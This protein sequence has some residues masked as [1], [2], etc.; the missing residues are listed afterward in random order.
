[1]T[2]VANEICPATPPSAGTSLLSRDV[3]IDVDIAL[4][5][6]HESPGVVV[7]WPPTRFQ[8]TVKDIGRPAG[9]ALWPY[10]TAYE[11]TDAFAVLN[12]GRSKWPYRVMWN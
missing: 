7:L 3:G 8:Y 6:D 12:R 9:G 2:R 11:S 4:P 1:M 10:D 5:P